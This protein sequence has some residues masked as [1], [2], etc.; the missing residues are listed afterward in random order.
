M[1]APIHAGGKKENKSATK[2]TFG[3]KLKK[4]VSRFAPG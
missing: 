2:G 4:R 3:K 1:A